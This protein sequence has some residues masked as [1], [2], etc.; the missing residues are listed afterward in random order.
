GAVAPRAGLA[1][2]LRSFPPSTQRA[3]DSRLAVTLPRGQARPRSLTP[4]R[5]APY[6]APL[7]AR[8]PQEG[9][10]RSGRAAGPEPR[11]PQAPAERAGDERSDER[12]DAAGEGRGSRR[13]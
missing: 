4:P 11:G 9:P 3:E 1:S 8:R 6:S 5:S 7:H 10:G 12:P 2:T 13:I